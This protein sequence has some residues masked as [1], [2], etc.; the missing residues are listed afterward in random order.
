MTMPWGPAVATGIGSM[1]GD[2]A[3]E[4][5]RIIAGELP[6]FVHVVEL[7]ARGP[8]ADMVGRTGALLAGVEAGLGLETTPDG[9]R[10]AGASGRQMRRAASFLNE[11]LDALEETAQR[12]GGPVK[13][14]VVG[15]WTMA[16]AVE[17]RSGERALSDAGAVAEIADALGTALVDHVADLRRRVPGASTIV[18]QVD[19]PGLPAVLDGRIDTASGLSRYAAVDPQVA[20]R[21]LGRVLSADPDAVTG[22][23]CCA[24]RP[25]VGLLREA[26]AAFVSLDLMGIGDE[27][28]QA[29]GQL[30]EAGDGLIAGTVPSTGS[31]RL[32]D[33]AASAAVRGLLDR[34]GLHDPRTLTRIAVSPTCGLAGASPSWARTALAACTAV[35]RVLRQDEGEEGPHGERG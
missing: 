29:L 32:S 25:P 7:P 21:V 20:G 34:L 12:Y 19:E 24:A 26:G 31:G 17:L 3:L 15:P 11:D 30:L 27:T 33:T 9:W 28:D 23:H 16:A 22:V 2:N 1:P 4:A 18:V 35:G 5:A 8:G 6:E 13:T 10:F 14:Q